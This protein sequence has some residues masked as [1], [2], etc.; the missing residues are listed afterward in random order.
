MSNP[1]SLLAPGHRACA[2]CGPA[3]AIRQILEASGPNTIIVEA[4]GCMEV[5]TTPYPYTA[6]RVP[7]LHVAFEN[8]AA[9]ASGVEAAYK[10]LRA[11]GAI[12]KDKKPNIIALAGDGGTFDIGMQALSGMLERGHNV[13]YVC[14]DNE[15]YMNTGIQRSSATP[16][17]AATTTSP[18]GKVIPGKMRR[19]K[20]IAMIAAAHDIPYVATASI[21]YPADLKKKV[22]K[23][24]EVDGPTF[25]HVFAPC[26]TGWRYGTEQTV[27]LAK[28]AVE[29]GIF[30]LYEITDENPLKPIVTKQL[31]KRKPVEEYLKTQGRFRH[32]FKPEKRQ[33]IID[34]IQAD[35]DKKCK[36]FNVDKPKD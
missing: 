13:L 4:T 9:A 2:G 7:W 19:K 29:T 18:A 1:E 36:L 5:T 26:P 6:W 14:Y 8:A 3:I 17:G 12:S 24:L 34:K 21:G 31:V 15:A 22:K 35:V 28:L 32:L 33:D 25:L 30:V 27:E 11:K 20:P 16:F 10:A 23:A